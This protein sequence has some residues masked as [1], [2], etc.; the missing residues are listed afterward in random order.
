MIV[1]IFIAHHAESIDT[2]VIKIGP[3]VKPGGL[4]CT[5]ANFLIKIF[6]WKTIK[7]NPTYPLPAGD[8]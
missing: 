6:N 7:R 5:S 4:K 3:V 8:H 1:S 2:L